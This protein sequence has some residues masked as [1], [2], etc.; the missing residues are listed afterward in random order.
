MYVIIYLYSYIYTFRVALD[1]LIFSNSQRANGTG[2][3]QAEVA[4]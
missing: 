1:S 4:V 2:P 3:E